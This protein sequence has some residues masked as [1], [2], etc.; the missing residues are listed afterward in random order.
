MLD[1]SIIVWSLCHAKGALIAVVENVCDL[2]LSLEEEHGHLHLDDKEFYFTFGN[3]VG[4]SCEDFKFGEIGNGEVNSFGNQVSN[5]F[6]ED[7]QCEELFDKFV[8]VE[9]GSFEVVCNVVLIYK[10][11]LSREIFVDNCKDGQN[12]LPFRR[13]NEQ[14]IINSE[15]CHQ[16]LPGKREVEFGVLSNKLCDD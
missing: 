2:S 14:F 10:S 16:K 3:E 8:V 5:G 11:T 6:I 15:H 1:Y 7:F 12:I 4:Q 13:L 9:Q